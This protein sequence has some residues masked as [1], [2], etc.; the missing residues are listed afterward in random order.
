MRDIQKQP[1]LTKAVPGSGTYNPEHPKSGTS[2]SFLGNRDGGFKDNG[3]PG[4]GGHDPI[5]A[6]K[7]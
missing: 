5:V 1:D 7:E 4:P 6:S 3:V 2:K